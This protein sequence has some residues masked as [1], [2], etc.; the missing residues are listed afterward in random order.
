LIKD[1]FRQKPLTYRVTVFLIVFIGVQII[2]FLVFYHPKTR[3]A[4]IVF[5]TVIVLD[6]LYLSVKL[7]KEAIDYN[8]L[9][10]ETKKLT[11]GDFYHKIPIDNLCVPAQTL[12][13][14]VNRIGDGLSAAV[15]EKLKSERLKTELITNVSHDIK[16][17]LT[18]IINYVDLL[19]K[20]D[21]KNEKASGYLDVLSTKSWR[22]K[23]LIEDLVEVS[24]ASSG[25]ISLN[26]E[27][28]NIVE[29]V[30]Q[31]M[32][33]FE[34]RFISSKL[35][36][37]FTIT[38][39]PIYIMADGRSTYRIIENIFSNV[40]KYA[41]EGTRVYVDIFA[42]D[43]SVAVSVKNISKNKLNITSEELLE[44]FVRGDLSRNTDGSGLG[45]S[46][47]QSLASLED[48][49]FEIILDGDL[50]KAVVKFNLLDSSH[51]SNQ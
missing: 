28:I 19:K 43:T 11:E 33:E 9:N 1:F 16:T 3:A 49:V 24:K 26:L 47:A 40:N 44:R 42:N 51:K 50:F 20:E 46:I 35:D 14:Y 15:E 10:N 39:E 45:L 6:Y 21:L 48:A 27:S 32:G 4:I 38:K 8:I 18:S 5:Y 12:G 22:L 34:D 29:L 13:N 37:I 36:I 25:N 30:K 7:I 17:P 23:T 41:L 31:A 2:D